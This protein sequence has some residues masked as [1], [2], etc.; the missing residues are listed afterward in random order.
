MKKLLVQSTVYAIALTLACLQPVQ[1][2][3][4]ENN[5]YRYNQQASVKTVLDEIAA[6]HKVNFLYENNLLQ[7]KTTGYR[8]NSSVSLQTALENLLTP[9]GLRFSKLDAKNYTIVAIKKTSANVDEDKYV[10]VDRRTEMISTSNNNTS[11]VLTKDTSGHEVVIK[12]RVVSDEKE[13]PIPNA[14]VLAKGTRI[15]TSTDAEGYFALKVPAGVNSLQIGHV[16]FNAL[17]ITANSRQLQTFRL[18][19]KSGQMNEV[20][21]TM[22]LFKRAKDNFTGS[23]TTVS[24]EQL[25]QVNNTNILDALKLFDPSVRIPDNVQFGSDPNRLPTITLRGTNNFPQ[26]TATSTTTTPSS[27]ADFMAN[28]QNNPNQPLFIL[29]GFEVS[30]QKIYDLDINRIGTITVLKDAAATSVYGSRAANGVI[31]VDTKQPLPGKLRLTY[32][33]MMQIAAPDL[34]VYDLTNAAEKLEVERLAGLYSTYASGIRPDADAVLRQNYANR[35]A[36]VQRGVNTY[37]LAMP[38]QTGFGQR[39]SL[40]M[41]GGDAFVRYGIDL[42]YY[43]NAGVMKNSDRSSYT[44]G[45]NFSYRY[46]GLLFKNNLSV[47]FNKGVNSNYGSF[48]EYTKQN[49]FWVPFDAAGNPVKILETVPSALGGTTNYLNPL[50][51]TTL[52]TTNENRYTNITNQT[53]IDWVLGKGFRL[54]GRLQI[55]SQ[56][57]GSDLFLPAQHT[58]FETIT[59]ITKKG[60][61]TKGEGNFFSYDASL[62]MDYSRQFGKHQF[63]NTTGGSIAETENNYLTVYVEGFPNDRLNQISFGNGYPPN[64]KPKYTNDVTRRISGF[65]NFNYTYDNRY[66]ADFSISSDGSSQFGTN[67]RFATFWSAGASWNLHKERFLRDKTYINLLRLRGSIGTTGDNKFQPFQGITTYQYYTDQNYR[68]Q[69]GA[70]LLGFGNEDLQWQ[71]TLKKNIGI[72]MGLLKNRILLSFDVYRENTTDLILD[73]TTPPSVGYS[74]Y[75]DNLAEIENN[76]YEFK[77]N[78]FILRN[79]KTRTFWNVYFNGSHNKDYIKQVSNSLKKLNQLNDANSTSTTSPDYNKQTKP[80]NRY[81]EGQSLNAIWAVRSLGI[82]PSNGRELFQKRDGT[83]TYNWDAADKVIVGNIIPEL[84]GSFGTSYSWKGLTAGVYFSYEYGGQIYNQTLIDRVEVTNYAYNVDRRVLLGR[85]KRPGDMTYFKGLVDENGATV[86]TA[87]YA[88]SRF[89]QNNNLV[90]V[91]S[92]SLSYSVSDKLNKKLGLSNTRFT[93]IANDI[94]RWS[95][96]EVERG[97]D[98]P[99]ARNFTI[100]LSTTF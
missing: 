88:T 9:L 66:V 58:S 73:V 70:I 96:I 27:G 23:S 78:A 29:D 94:K 21:V 24:G 91:E 87:T 17:D 69:L 79:E 99:F 38:V 42:A 92:I 61:Y 59:D 52:N 60:S 53:N 80:Q 22:G 35:L 34:N 57:D 95:A 26:T 13:Q 50:Y 18:Q 12:G 84:R 89:V 67:K 16:N 85:W 81:E 14:S 8:F 86:S 83:I 65:S 64:S 82:D 4:N 25:R 20:V 2:F 62:Q 11:F 51:N 31:V 37:W 6:Y 46:K 76:G 68:G 39:H 49:P 41:E 100:N 55:I 90:N 19:P 32:N 98:Y 7:N 75:R 43:N 44:G 48:S 45:M 28:Y 10:P 77:L 54:T 3:A 1:G 33:G 93:F 56:K 5:R 36:A 30:L 63:M 74:S 71:Q 47:V 15:G 97:L 72:D 40:F